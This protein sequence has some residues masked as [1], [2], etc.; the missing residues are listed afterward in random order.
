MVMATV[1]IIVERRDGEIRIRRCGRRK[2]HPGDVLCV[3][4]RDYE[5]DEAMA[6]DDPDWLLQDKRGYSYAG[7][8]QMRLEVLP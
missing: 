5:Y 3:E 1:T 6:C 4:L 7:G 8:L 2:L